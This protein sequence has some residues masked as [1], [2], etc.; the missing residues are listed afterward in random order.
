MTYRLARIHQ[1]QTT[2]GKTDGQTTTM[3]KTCTYVENG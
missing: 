1:L 3:P 2:K